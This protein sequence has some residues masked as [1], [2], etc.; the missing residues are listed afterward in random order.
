MVQYINR[1]G[2]KYTFTKLENGNVLFNF[3]V[4]KHF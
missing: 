4:V 2:D 1:Y 3:L